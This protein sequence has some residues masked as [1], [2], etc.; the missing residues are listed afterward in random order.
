VDS[1]ECDSEWEGLKRLFVNK[2]SHMNMRKMTKLLCTD[3]S[4]RDMYPNLAKLA[5]TAVLIPVSTAECF[6]YES[7]K[8][9]AKEPPKNFN[10]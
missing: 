7:Y 3:A 1:A 10:T 9:S 8:D 2:F 6:S 4:L 5:S